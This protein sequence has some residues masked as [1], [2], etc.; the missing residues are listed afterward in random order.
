MNIFFKK[1]SPLSYRPDIDGLRALAVLIVILFHFWPK[2][3]PGGFVGV[4]IFFLISGYLI[5]SI[6]CTKKKQG[7]FSFKEFYLHRIKRILP[8]F[9]TMLF[10]SILLAYFFL[11]PEDFNQFIKSAIYSSTYS[12]NI[13]FSRAFDYFSPNALEKPLLHTWSLSVEEQYYLIWPA[14]LVFGIKRFKKNIAF[15][16]IFLF[17]SS[18]LFSIYFTYQNTSFIYYSVFSRA[19]EFMLGSIMAICTQRKQ[20]LII[21]NNEKF[22]LNLISFIGL[23]LIIF[24]CF[25]FDK[26]IPFPGFLALFPTLGSGMIIYSGIYSKNSWINHLLSKKIFCKIGLIS[27][28]LYLFHWPVISFWHY[29]FIDSPSFLLGSLMLAVVFLIALGSYHFIETPLR[30]LKI[31]FSKAL[32]FYQILPFTLIFMI[33][34]LAKETNGFESRYHDFFLKEITFP[35]KKYCWTSDSPGCFLGKKQ[36]TKPKV[37]FFGDSHAAQFFPFFDE[38]GKKYNFSIEALSAG[39]CYPLLNTVNSL[40]SH[41]KSLN[42]YTECN[43]IIEFVSTHYDNYDVFILGGSYNSYIEKNASA[44][45]NNFEFLDEFKNSIKF[46]TDH[47]KKIIVL[48]DIPYDP[49][50]KILYF[51]RKQLFLKE[52]ISYEPAKPPILMKENSPVL[53]KKITLSFKNTYFFDSNKELFS[54][55]QTLP[56]YKGYLIYKDST[57]LNEYAS[58]L[59][60][61]RYLASSKN[62]LIEKLTEWK[63]IVK[64]S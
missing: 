58:L 19:Y 38:I 48:G 29:F 5:T 53:I 51:L 24:S 17:L 59:L 28:S 25:F 27:Y 13:Y 60:A 57:H 10:F 11:L 30:S 49:N 42:T 52:N 55:I 31:N 26:D 35:D 37:L 36:N 21:K 33:A 15:Y 47:Q 22:I 61:D 32:C 7:L 44:H 46:L 3:L 41:D 6:I 64:E 14:I 9:F 34:V 23:I 12:S 45:P 63:V 8:A 2:L 1:T 39:S 40:P 4:D 18:L 54:S 50:N 43:K 56:F 16:I 20:S 62:K